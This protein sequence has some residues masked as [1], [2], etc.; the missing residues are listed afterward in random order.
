M[1]FLAF[2]YLT[3]FAKENAKQN[4]RQNLTRI[5]E[6]GTCVFYSN[7]PFLFFFSSTRLTFT[8]KL[9][10]NTPPWFTWKMTMWKMYLFTN[11]F[12]VWEHLYSWFLWQRC[13]SWMNTTKRNLEGALHCKWAPNVCTKFLSILCAQ[14]LW[15]SQ[16]CTSATVP[17]LC[18]ERAVCLKGYEMKERSLLLS[19]YCKR[20]LQNYHLR[21]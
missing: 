19:F 1:S 10:Q 9:L 15:R 20:N 5:M 7:S 16:D 18:L 4:E 14:R 6:S 17:S 11:M 12:P 13:H 3:F 2:Q 8:V 21:T